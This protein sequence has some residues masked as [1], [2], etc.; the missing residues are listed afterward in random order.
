MKESKFI[1]QSL[2]NLNESFGVF[3]ADE[4]TN[5]I[6]GACY[7]KICSG[8]YTRRAKITVCPKDER[9][10]RGSN[11]KKDPPNPWGRGRKICHYKHLFSDD[12]ARSVPRKENNLQLSLLH[13]CIACIERYFFFSFTANSLTPFLCP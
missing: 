6:L 9:R 10:K 3:V 12:R 2:R 5:V 7:I 8:S 13:G 4:Q 1:F 11:T